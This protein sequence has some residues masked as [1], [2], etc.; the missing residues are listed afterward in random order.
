MAE[1]PASP[2]VIGVFCSY[3]PLEL[4]EA[5]GFRPQLISGL[6]A[7]RSDPY[8]P[9]NL[10]AYVRH[11]ATYLNSQ[12]AKQ[13]LSGLIV[14]DSCF[15]MLRLWDSIQER[16]NFPFKYLLKV[17]RLNSQ[18]AIDFFS[19]ELEGLAEDLALVNGTPFYKK[20]LIAAVEIY[21]QFRSLNRR[22]RKLMLAGGR[23]QLAARFTDLHESRSVQTRE[24]L[25]LQLEEL[26]VE[27]EATEPENGQPHRPRL[28]VAGSH[29]LD[30]RL[31]AIL[32]DL[33]G[34]V[35]G[36]DSCLYDGVDRI[37]VDSD[38]EDPIAGLAA[39]YLNK[40]PCPRMRANREHLFQIES[41]IDTGDYDGII[42][43]QMKA[44][45]LHSYNLPIWR[46]MIDQTK[47]PLLILEVEDGEWASPRTV[48]RLEAF[49]E[50]LCI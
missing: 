8:L 22:L 30:H 41:Q 40:V 29:F 16:A 32:T 50:S 1:Q 15:P 17:P 2:A 23:P 7:N 11:C 43:F 31:M 45:T 3:V 12:E 37:M 10:C 14:T 24:G 18:A 36:L 44:C 19:H 34:E 26:L 33:G 38:H 35:V 47:V 4:I 48:T 28:L 25:N 21:N 20:R 27:M 49:L 13:E 6:E 46:T 42:F 39:S 9:A 5:A